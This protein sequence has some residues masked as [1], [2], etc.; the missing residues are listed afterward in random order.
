MPLND[1]TLSSACFKIKHPLKLGEY[2]ELEIIV[3][4]KEIISVKG[5]VSRLEIPTYAV[6]QFFA[7]GTDER[8]NSM[9]S[10]DQLKKIMN[11]YLMAVN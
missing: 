7:F 11:E 5:I 6:A 3:P 4:N 9:N 10:Y 1:L 2:I 8:Y